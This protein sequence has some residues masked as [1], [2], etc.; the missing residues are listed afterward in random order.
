MAIAPHPL[1]VQYLARHGIQ[2]ALR[3]DGRAT[4]LV[5]DTYRIHL[6]GAPEGWLAMSA[7]LCPLPPAGVVRDR[8]LVKV[9][10]HAAGMLSQQPSSCVIDPHEDSLWLQHMIRPDAVATEMDEAVGHF[11][12]ALSFWAQVVRHAA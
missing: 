5:D 4:L 1:I 2:D 8:F 10:S 6:R 12:N 3:A 9:G 11:A 7:R